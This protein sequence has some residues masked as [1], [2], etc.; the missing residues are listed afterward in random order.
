MY[1]VFFLYIVHC[2]VLVTSVASEAENLTLYSSSIQGSSIQTMEYSNIQTL[3]SI[4][5]NPLRRS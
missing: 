4:K 1:S 5:A 3:K 2:E